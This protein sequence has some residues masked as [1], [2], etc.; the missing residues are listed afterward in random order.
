[1]ADTSGSAEYLKT[2]D[3]KSPAPTAE[4]NKTKLM[5]SCA[6]RTNHRVGGTLQD[7]I[8]LLM[9]GAI[10]F[11]VIFKFLTS[12]V[13]MGLS[14][15]T[16]NHEIGKLLIGL[17]LL[18]NVRSISNSLVNNLILPIVEPLL[19]FL[20]CRLNIYYGPFKLEFGEFVSDLIVFTINLFIIYVVFVVLS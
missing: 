6:R 16:K 20:L 1:M 5:Y 4:E 2:L 12:N 13:S 15:F 10:C 8:G 9:V 14:G 19:P 17:M 7:L 18:N 11:F 3:Q